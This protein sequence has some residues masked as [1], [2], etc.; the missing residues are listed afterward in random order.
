M[1][2]ERRVDLVG[3]NR[4]L[5]PEELQFLDTV[6]AA[7]AERERVQGEAERSELEA[8]RAALRERATEAA[9]ASTAE[10][11]EAAAGS[12]FV[13]P[14]LPKADPRLPSAAAPSSLTRPAIR[15]VVRAKGRESHQHRNT[16]TVIAA[17]TSAASGLGL[18][19]QQ[20]PQQK[21]RPERPTSSEARYQPCATVTQKDTRLAHAGKAGLDEPSERAPLEHEPST[22]HAARLASDTASP[23]SARMPAG[24]AE[25]PAR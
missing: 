3:K 15:A 19:H 14:S 9:A 25:A 2:D 8:F 12:R 23:T 10:T 4:P 21:A 18:L 1:T 13:G 6:A 20:Q 22:M 11:E 17:P 16:A 24:V 7:E 5:D